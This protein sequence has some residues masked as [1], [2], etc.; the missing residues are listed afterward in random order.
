MTA[1][2]DAVPEM[3]GRPLALVT[4]A[5]SGIGLELARQC[6]NN[7]FD[8]VI[9]SDDGQIETAAVVFR[10]LGAEV[11]AID[12]DLAAAE[13]VARLVAAVGGRPVDA[14]LA[15]AGVGL[16]NGFLDQNFGDVETVVATNVTGTLRLIH[17]VGRG[18]RARG[19]GRILITGS[20][21]GF[22]PG[23][24]HAVYNATKAFLN[25]FSFALRDELTDTGVTVTCL[26][27]GPTETNIFDRAGLQDTKAA[28]LKKDDPAAVAAVGFKAM[29]DGE[30]DVVSGWKSKLI[31]A[32]ANITP[33]SVLAAVHGRGAKPGSAS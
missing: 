15:N 19:Q 25:N 22:V 33:S 8:L 20:I 10:E 32:A 12:V 4:G 21:G 30:G 17:A 3:T 31:A 6:A 18:M 23:S 14:L 11:V 1:P 29:M 13:G 26:M 5:S 27:P 7:G 16:A 24:Y 28:E 9:A 2:K